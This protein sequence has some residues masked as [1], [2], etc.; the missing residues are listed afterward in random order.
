MYLL[1]LVY[2]TLF[3][4]LKSTFISSII[5]LQQLASYMQESALQKDLD[6]TFINTLFAW[7]N[8]IYLKQ[9]NFL[10]FIHRCIFKNSS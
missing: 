1:F 7:A 3:Q 4:L 2:L 5:I 6:N 10:A 8:C 9:L